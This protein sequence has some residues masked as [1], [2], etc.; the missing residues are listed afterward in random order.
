MRLLSALGDRWLNEA[1]AHTPKAASLIRSELIRSHKNLGRD[2][3]RV[4]KYK[5]CEL[6][7]VSKLPNVGS[8]R[9]Q[10]GNRLRSMSL[11]VLVMPP[12]CLLFRNHLKVA[13]SMPSCNIF[14]ARYY[15]ETHNAEPAFTTRLSKIN[16]PF[17]P[18]PFFRAV[19]AQNSQTSAS[20]ITMHYRC[21]C[22]QVRELAQ[23]LLRSNK[24]DI[25]AITPLGIWVSSSKLLELSS[26][27]LISS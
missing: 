17:W 19:S 16:P 25:N 13:V 22:R 6:W 5:N 2:L 4:L 12:L 21:V 26:H 10:Q 24:G 8:S 7:K 23:L 18:F 3:L 9:Y 27:S 11:P 20:L 1:T 14:M 15:Q